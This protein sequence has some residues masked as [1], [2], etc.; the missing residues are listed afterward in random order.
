MSLQDLLF[1]GFNGRVV[2]LEQRSGELVWERKCPK[3]SGQMMALLVQGERIY[4]SSAGYTYCLDA[5]NG[6]QLWFNTL[7]GNGHGS[8]VPRHGGVWFQWIVPGCTLKRWPSASGACVGRVY[9]RWIAWLAC[10]RFRWVIGKRGGFFVARVERD[11]DWRRDAIRI[12]SARRARRES[13]GATGRID[14]AGGTVW[15]RK[16]DAAAHDRGLMSRRWRT[17]RE[18]WIGERLAHG[19]RISDSNLLPWRSVFG[20]HPVASRTARRTVQQ[21]ASCGRGEFETDRPQTRRRGQAAEECSLAECGLRVSLARALVTRPELLLLDEP[22]AA[23]DDLLR[24]QLNEELL[25]IWTEQRWTGLFVTHNVPRQ[26]FSA[27]ACW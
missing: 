9:S 8:S 22:F 19:I 24:Q 23:L 16:I 15:L 6:E 3:P 11:R 1:V 10:T 2:A 17:A 20:Q 21:S 27:S 5:L 4:A 12:W 14:L 7:K 18:R 26:C 13:V 25:R